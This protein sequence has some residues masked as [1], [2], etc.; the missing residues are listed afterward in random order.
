MSNM[1][2][3]RLFALIVVLVLSYFNQTVASKRTNDN[4]KTPL[5]GSTVLEDSF[6]KEFLTK[7]SSKVQ[8][9]IPVTDETRRHAIKTHTKRRYSKIKLSEQ[10][11]N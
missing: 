11:M 2:D 8:Q 6:S 3:V 5:S 4:F 7:C 9:R 10:E 1:A